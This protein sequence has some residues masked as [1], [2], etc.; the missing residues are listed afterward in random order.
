MI[1][2]KQGKLS[3]SALY[4]AIENELSLAKQNGAYKSELPI[5]SAQDGVVTVRGKKAIM[6]ASSN[7]L[8]LANH[9]RIVN[10]AKKALDTYG[11]GMASTRFM[12]GTQPIH[13]TLEEKIAEFV[14]CE[15]A[16]LHAS[17]FA[18]NG[19]FF[20]AMV[21]SD[22][23][24]TDYRD[25]IYS[26]EGNHASSVDGV[27]LCEASVKTTDSKLFSYKNLA[28]LESDLQSDADKNYRLRIINSDGVFNLAGEVVPLAELV[29]LAKKYD[30]IL[31]IDDSHGTGVIG[32]SGRGTPEYANVFGQVDLLSG[33]LGKALGGASGGYIAGRKV[34][35][36]FLRQKSRT[37]NFSNNVPSSLVAAALEALAILQEDNA[38]IER[39]QANTQF[40]RKEIQN[41]GYKI[42]GV[43]HPIV[44]VIV[45]E[46]N[47]LKQMSNLLLEEGVFA[48]GVAHPIVPL[49]SARLRVQIS[50]THT[51]ADLDCALTAFAKVGRSLGVIS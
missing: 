6:L 2:V 36:D 11:F 26:E 31:Y 28:K 10:A 5:E 44:P 49:A 22:L 33:T 3:N 43:D 12:C 4:Q 39:L 37:Y 25:V 34:L 1:S 48:R 40:F 20:T 18:A 16:F 50:A 41:L 30:A 14:G 8:G 7:Y 51:Q 47:T 19:G 15:D 17:C 32:K 42:L 24:F 45:G 29:T 21:G 35:I 46:A 38:L 23:G 9:P 27:R 13:R